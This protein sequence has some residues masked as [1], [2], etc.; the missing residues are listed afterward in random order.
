[1]YGCFIKQFLQSS[2]YFI[3]DKVYSVLGKVHFVI[4]VHF[5]FTALNKMLRLRFRPILPVFTSNNR[6]FEFL[7]AIS[8][9]ISMQK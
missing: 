6:I 1:M 3:Y 7:K 2:G 8:L 4:T 9:S 5:Q